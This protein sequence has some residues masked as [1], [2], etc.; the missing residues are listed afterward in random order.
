MFSLPRVAEQPFCHLLQA[1]Q[2]RSSS[3][4]WE[5]PACPSPHPEQL[6][7][8]SSQNLLLGADA[9]PVSGKGWCSCAE[10]L[11]TAAHRICGQSLPHRT[12]QL[13]WDHQQHLWDTLGVLLKFRTPVFS[14]QGEKWCKQKLLA[15]A[16][17]LH[18]TV[19]ASQE[20][21]S[22]PASLIFFPALWNTN[23]HSLCSLRLRSSS[24]TAPSAPLVMARLWAL[25]GSILYSH[26]DIARIHSFSTKI[27]NFCILQVSSD[28][29]YSFPLSKNYVK[30]LI[31]QARKHKLILKNTA[32]ALF[33]W[34]LTE[35]NLRQELEAHRTKWWWQKWSIPQSIMKPK[36][37]LQM[38]EAGQLDECI[39]TSKKCTKSSLFTRFFSADMNIVQFLK[40]KLNFK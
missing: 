4:T 20:L 28:P 40:I 12:L 19:P 23:C 18:P 22:L 10:G 32:L 7:L 13:S 8:W 29:T 11:R 15:S 37:W 25:C 1:G 35:S 3:L 9:E 39:K 27:Q 6:N 34:H 33:K 21:P 16:F 30:V 31:A 2:H 5:V 38:T 14:T 26:A 17:F 24:M 36:N